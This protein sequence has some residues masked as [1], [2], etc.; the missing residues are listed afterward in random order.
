MLIGSRYSLDTVSG[1]GSFSADTVS[2][3][4]MIHV[5]LLHTLTSLDSM[6]DT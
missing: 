2:Y 3:V 6:A 5:L 4:C 1:S